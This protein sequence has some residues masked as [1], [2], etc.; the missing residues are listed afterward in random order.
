MTVI[1]YK[2]GV[3]A[4]DSMACRDGRRL[5]VMRPKITRGKLGLLGGSGRSDDLL[6]AANWFI[7]GM[8][9]DRHPNFSDDKEDNLDLLWAKNDGSLWWAD[10][11]LL[12]VPRTDIYAIGE[13]TAAHFVE[14]AMFAGME[15]AEAVGLAIEHCIWIGG[16]VQSERLL[17]KPKCHV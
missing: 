3:M 11:R 2:N 12:F 17:T 6:H 5:P 7:N 8:Y 10:K 13:T 15:A 1:A 14:G 16:I 9:P 4:A